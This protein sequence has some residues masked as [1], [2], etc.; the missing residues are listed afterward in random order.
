MS[1]LDKT[2]FENCT[3]CTVCTEYCPVLR[4]NIKYPGPKQAG[5]DGARLRLKDRAM[6][7]A[8]LKYCTNCKRCEVACPS[9]VKIGDIV[10][11]AKKRYEPSRPCVRDAILAHTD[12]IGTF[13]GF[14]APVV[15]F[16]LR[17]K[18]VKFVLEKVLGIDAKRSFPGYSFTTF[19]KW[20]Q[21]NERKRQLSFAE[22]VG[23]F[24]GCYINYNN[25][26]LG[27]DVIKAL[28]AFGVGVELLRREKC[29][30]VALIVNRFF[31]AATKNAELNKRAL[32]EF[33]VDK[34]MPVLVASSTCTLT[35]REEYPNVLG[36]DTTAL[37][38]GINLASRYLHTLLDTGRMV[39]L[40]PLKLRVA[41][42]TPCHMEKL[43][44]AAYSIELLKSIPGLELIPLESQCCGIAG[45]Y[46]FKKEN[47]TTAQDIGENLFKQIEAAE[48]DM[49]VT[50]CETC[51]WQI[52]MSTGVRCEHP[53]T[54]FAMALE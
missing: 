3:K 19:R 45:T 26:Q 28:N 46:G 7:D 44:W 4:A 11:L 20:Y 37:H 34:K 29:C 8:A 48:V 2:D 12:F 14:F 21:K 1:L 30:G 41:Y 42:H 32:S 27:R 18:P 35:M 16:S 33:I 25:P 43:G 22:R 54:V 47:Y 6:Y 50:D 13:A 23:F 17:L 53:V 49:V 10:Q 51:K 40:K 52:E 36:V 24:H 38:H 15:N 5:P 39:P 9:D 31:A